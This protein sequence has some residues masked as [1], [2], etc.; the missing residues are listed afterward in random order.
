MMRTIGDNTKIAVNSNGEQA[1]GAGNTQLFNV[2]ADIADH[3]ENDPSQLG[4]DLT[5]LDT[6]ISKLQTE[7][8]DVGSR[9][10]R[11]S[12]MRDAAESRIVSLKTQLSD[13]EDIDLPMTITELTL[14]QTA[15]QAALAATAKVVQPSLV[16]FLK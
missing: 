6:A 11:V 15:Y 10:N 7:I 13:I 12:Q 1:F 8:A 16:D 3:L 2:L 4:N 9:T 14:Q 5:R